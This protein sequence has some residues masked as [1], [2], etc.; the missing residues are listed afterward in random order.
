[1]KG[2]D[3]GTRV[4]ERTAT[5][6]LTGAHTLEYLRCRLIEE[7]QRAIRYEV[8]LGLLVVRVDGFS[9][10]EDVFGAHRPERLM[11]HTANVLLGAVRDTD[12]VGR[13][14]PDRL[15]V[16]LPFGGV[17]EARAVSDRVR[18]AVGAAV[19]ERGLFRNPTAVPISI[20]S[21]AFPAESPSLEA[22]VALVDDRLGDTAPDFEARAPGRRLQ[23]KAVRP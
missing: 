20:A 11:A 9:A 6:P 18:A 2:P 4:F 19:F 14:G 1:M 7:A 15:G 16:I 10:L 17:S 12:I 23:L 13:Y 8:P 5:D 21:A 3:A 22:L